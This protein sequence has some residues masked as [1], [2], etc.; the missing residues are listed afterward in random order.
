MVHLFTF[1]GG[2][3]FLDAPGGT[4]KTFLLNTVLATIRSRC[5]IALAT[6]SS[7]IAA[8]LL[9]GGRTLHSRFKIPLDAHR[10]ELPM[11]SIKKGTV[12][13]KII[14]DCKAIIVDEAPMI[15]RCAFEA[16][17]RTLR[18][19]RS[20]DAPFGGIP[21]LLCG[22][23]RQI[24]PVVR[25][26]TRAN[27]VDAS[28][29]HSYLWPSISVLHLTTNMRVHLRGDE[30]AG[31]FAEYL[32]SIG[33]GSYPH[34]EL[35]NVITLP[36]FISCTE[37]LEEMKRTIY[38]NLQDHA[39]D[40][41]WLS[42]RAILAP[43]NDTVNRINASL[44]QQF[45]GNVITY[46]SVDSALND[47]EA[48]HFPTEFLNSIE[49]SGLPPHE[50]TLKQGCP[51][52]LLRSLDPPRLMNGT[53]RIMTKGSANLIEAKI[54]QGPFT[55]EVVM[56]PRIPLIPS[57]SELPFQFRRVQFPVRPCFA[58]TINKSQGQTLQEVG[59]DLST[60][61]FCHGM[62]YVAQ[63]RTGSPNSVVVHAPGRVT[64]NVV[65]SEVL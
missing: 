25:N 23:F 5:E 63:S 40:D 43:L 64:T 42:E 19:I 7:G 53:Q 20:V 44:I 18:D 3:F 55:G 14:I 39:N 45:P 32:L 17:D 52:I 6:A 58:M 30:Q 29:K 56:V 31:M 26:G 27:I 41:K 37:T 49:L 65:Y 24:L 21:T 2:V 10:Q 33:N 59:I 47:D 61:C 50:L 11:C 38:P 1:A 9:C 46:R 54:S 4:G 57:D 16:V 8:T 51:I 62:L 15:H 60:P 36:T 22:D 28:L 12:L 48:V 34:T 13:A 35:P